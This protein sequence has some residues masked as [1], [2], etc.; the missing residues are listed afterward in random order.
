[1]SVSVSGFCDYQHRQGRPDR[2]AQIRVDMRKAYA[3]SRNT[4]SPPRLV[5]TLRKQAHAVGQKRIG[6]LIHEEHIQSKCK[7][8]FKPC[9]TDSHHY[10]PGADNVL[11]RQFSVS[12]TTPTW[13]TDITYISI[14]EG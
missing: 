12:S 11:A 5:E 6:Q 4:Y 3:A 8:G 10:L 13:V 7:G 9:T 2:D 14:K 1:M